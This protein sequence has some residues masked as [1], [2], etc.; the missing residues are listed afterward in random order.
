MTKLTDRTRNK[1]GRNIDFAVV[2]EV[3]EM[4]QNVI[5]KSIEQS[6]SIKD[7]PKLWLITT[8]GFVFEDSLMMSL[9]KL[10]QLYTVKMI[11]W[12]ASEDLTGY[13][14]RIRRW[15]SG[16]IQRAG[17]SRTLHLEW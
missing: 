16:Q 6:Q 14:H 8:D 2:D 15:R 4:K 13:T 10:M 3:H 12:Q 5:V 1:E 11:R 17:T 9:R 7:N